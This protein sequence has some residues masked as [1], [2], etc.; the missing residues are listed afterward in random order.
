M[1]SRFQAPPLVGALLAGWM[2]GASADAVPDRHVRLV[3]SNMAHEA[4]ECA[5]YYSVVVF[6]LR[7][8]DR[9]DLANGYDQIRQQAA[10]WALLLTLR[11]GLKPETVTAVV[12]QGFM[13]QMDRIDDDTANIAILTA[14]YALPCQEVINEPEKRMRYWTEKLPR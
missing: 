12:K 9:M 5:A 8:S 4:S 1:G 14:D 3:F 2:F 10:E 11:A 6:A 7:N 13:N